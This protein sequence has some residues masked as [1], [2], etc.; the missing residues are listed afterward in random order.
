MLDR[1]KE[2][3]VTDL[4]RIAGAN[5]RSV[6][7]WAASRILLA[8]PQTDRAGTGTARLFGADEA[9]IACLMQALLER[10]TPVG[11]MLRVGFVIRDELLTRGPMRRGLLG[12]IAR[13]EV[14]AWL[15]NFPNQDD[16]AAMILQSN[17]SDSFAS[18][19]AQMKEKPV[20]I[21]I[22]LTAALKGLQAEASQA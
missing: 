1:R 8:K 11:E 22:D 18:V 21:V 5:P 3:T 13:G 20:A 6:Q 17:S 2:Y 14:Q 12:R 9:V 19:F 10:Q 15:V 16:P 4:A 7:H